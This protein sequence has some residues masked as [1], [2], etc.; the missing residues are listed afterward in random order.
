MN[1]TERPLEERITPNTPL[2]E[3]LFAMRPYRSWSESTFESYRHDIQHMESHFISKGWEPTLGTIRLHLVNEWVKHL[4][5]E[6]AAAGTIKRR[7]AACSSLYTFY[8]NLG[9]LAS[10]PFRAVEAPVG[11]SEYASALMELEDVR[12][13]FQ[14]VTRLKEKGIDIEVTTKVMFYS[15]LRN[16]ALCRLRVLDVLF[17]QGLLQVDAG[18][19]NSKHKIQYIPLPPNL[20][21]LL[22]TH[23]ETQGLSPDDPLLLG[24]AGL[25]L[26][27]KALNR[28][29]EKLNREL[30]W[31]GEKR[32]TPHG[33]RSSIATL[34]SERGV[35]VKAIKLVLGHADDHLQFGQSVW[36]Y[37]RKHR[38]WIEQIRM[39]VTQLEKELD[40]WDEI[41]PSGR[42]E[43]TTAP[44]EL[45]ERTDLD[46]EM[47][48]QLFETHPKLALAI[49]QHQW[50]KTPQM[51]T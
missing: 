7:I 10:N 51:G 32:V 38:R 9:I 13:V 42:K 36:I 2:M 35:D 45:C 43:T 14:A 27:E 24:L 50:G 16:N 3:A 15:G 20:L 31:T 44:A 29:T 25:P 33:F 1:T 30:A 37:I 12:Q 5:A 49:I 23:I 11:S 48:M 26:R 18:V 19:V 17:E 8:I 39:H 22:I 6:Q 41:E 4:Q 47:L 28:L 40:Q 21:T 46:E 34:L